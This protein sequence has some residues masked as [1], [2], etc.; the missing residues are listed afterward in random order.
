MPYSVMDEFD[1]L[2]GSIEDTDSVDTDSDSDDFSFKV[3]F[4]PS[5][6]LLNEEL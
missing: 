5:E 1:D 2:F 4:D 3:S 6:E